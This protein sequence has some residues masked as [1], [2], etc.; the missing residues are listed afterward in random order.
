MR[1][2]SELE[3]EIDCAVSPEPTLR[4]LMDGLTQLSLSPE[5]YKATQL[6]RF[7][8]WLLSAIAFYLWELPPP[9]SVRVLNT[10]IMDIELAIMAFRGERHC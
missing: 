8:I 5:E 1:F 9:P 6:E 10:E 4:G 7:Q 3:P 2:Q